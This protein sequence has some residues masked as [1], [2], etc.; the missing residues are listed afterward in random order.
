M[1]LKIRLAKYVLCCVTPVVTG[2]VFASSP[3]LAATL[4]SSGGQLQIY[5][6]NQIPENVETL[7][8]TNTFATAELGSTT[9]EAQAVASFIVDASA[10]AANLTF[11][12]GEIYQGIADSMSQVLGSFSIEEPNTYFTFDFS[13]SLFVQTSIDTPQAE[14]A[15]AL[16]NLFFLLI[17]GSTQTVYDAFGLFGNLTT[18]GDDDYLQPQINGNISLTNS[19]ISTSFG[20]TQESANVSVEGSL[21]RLF[22]TPTNLTLLAATTNRSSVTSVPVPEPSSTLGLVGF[23]GSMGIWFGAKRKAFGLRSKLA[24]KLH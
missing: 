19:S 12:E 14:S 3:T 10:S 18:P 11:G 16:T 24:H 15:N 2:F 8:D 1:K 7:T 6:I 20:G 5:N 21:Q 17:D 22:T 13:A 4:S 23:L 9:A